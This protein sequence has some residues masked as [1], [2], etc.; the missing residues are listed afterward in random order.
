MVSIDRYFQAAYR[1]RIRAESHRPYGM[2]GELAAHINGDR[3]GMLAEP[4]DA[5]ETACEIPGAWYHTGDIL[6]IGG[7]AVMVTSVTADTV[8]LIR[9]FMGTRPREHAAGMPVMRYGAGAVN[10]IEYGAERI[11]PLRVKCAWC[12]GVSATSHEF[13]PGCGAPRKE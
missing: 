7:E 10:Y 2:I 9:G 13:C 11:E 6:Q 8:S 4:L 12:G 3:I 1:E 5:M